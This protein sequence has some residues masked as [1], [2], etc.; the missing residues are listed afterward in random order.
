MYYALSRLKTLR[1]ADLRSYG[2][3]PEI[4]GRLPVLCHLDP[5]DKDALRKILTEPKNALIKQYQ[6]MFDIDN[7]ELSFSKEVIELIVDTA[8]EFK[9]GARGLR[10]ICETIML[11]LMFEAPEMKDQKSIEITLEYANNKI[12]QIRYKNLNAA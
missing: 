3:I 8:Y 4:I 5:L 6:Y 7:I 9:L 1:P 2:L 10:N 12:E 11:D